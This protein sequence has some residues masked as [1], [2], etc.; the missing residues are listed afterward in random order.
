MDTNFDLLIHK[1]SPNY[2][3]M[4]HIRFSL[5]IILLPSLH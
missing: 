5:E 2:F 1:L 3:I 4:S